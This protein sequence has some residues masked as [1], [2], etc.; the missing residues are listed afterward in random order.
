MSLLF[1]GDI[2]F[3]FLG[4]PTHKTRTANRELEQEDLRH[5]VCCDINPSM[6]AVGRQRA[7]NLGLDS[8]RLSWIEGD[9]Q[10]LPFENESFDAYTIAF[11]I[12]NVVRIEE[13]IETK[14]LGYHDSLG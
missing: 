9:A 14:T 12:R 8:Q 5:V 10:K 7:L 11:G 3:R 13:V 4:F 6:L 2:A 1:A